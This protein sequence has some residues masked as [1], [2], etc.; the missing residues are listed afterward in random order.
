MPR[1]IEWIVTASSVGGAGKRAA[2]CAT[3]S[4]GFA[5]RDA[6]RPLARVADLPGLAARER[7]AELRQRVRGGTYDNRAVVE[8]VARRIVES[9]DL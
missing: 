9:G 3:T 1:R 7:I 4:V 2:A 6:T 5:S 8:Q